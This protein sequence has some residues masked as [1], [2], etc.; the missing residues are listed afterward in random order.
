MKNR[1][2]RESVSGEAGFRLGFVHDPPRPGGSGLYQNALILYHLTTARGLG[3]SRTHRFGECK[4]EQSPFRVSPGRD[5]WRSPRAR[6]GSQ[7]LETPLCTPVR[8]G[9][10]GRCRVTAGRATV[11]GG[12]PGPAHGDRHAGWLWRSVVLVE[13]GMIRRPRLRPGSLIAHAARPGCRAPVA[14][15]GRC[16]VSCE[17]GCATRGSWLVRVFCARRGGQPH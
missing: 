9:W 5:L 14:A 1:S 2:H 17:C 13:A 7:R 6:C 11:A 3:G 8:E 12:R 10:G 15:R 4:G 16:V